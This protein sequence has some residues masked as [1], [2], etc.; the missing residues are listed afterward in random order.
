M[1]NPSDTKQKLLRIA[2]DLIWENSYGSVSVDDICRRAKVLKGSFYHFFPSKSDLAVEAFEEY[3]ILRKQQLDHNFSPDLSPEDRFLRYADQIYDNQ[4]KRFALTK[5]VG[6]CPFSS[7]GSELSTQDEK[8]RKKAQEIGARVR[9]YFET[10]LRD[11]AGAGQ[12]GPDAI[13]ERASQLYALLTGTLLQARIS[14]D[15]SSIQNFKPAMLRLLDLAGQ[16]ARKPRRSA[17]AR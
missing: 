16:T 14:N 12:T 17:L 8:V 11:A 9:G 4:K 7:V 10:A 1:K 15:L 6:G 3:W 5:K 13:E 2:L